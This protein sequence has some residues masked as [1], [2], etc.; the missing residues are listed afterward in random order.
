MIE[1]LYLHI[2]FCHAKCAYCDFCS[3]AERAEL[4]H[5]D[6]Y[7]EKLRALIEQL[8]GL[9]LFE[10][11]RSAYIGGGTPS[12]LM[13]DSLHLLVS[14]INTLSQSSLSELSVE[15]NPESLDDERLAALVA[16]GATRISMGLQSTHKLELA[17]LGRIHSA[18]QGLM[19]AQA[20]LQTPLTLSLDVM[21]G[22]PYQTPKSWSD[23]LDNLIALKPHH[24]S[25]YPLIIEEGTGFAAAVNR[26]D[27][28]E[29][30]EDLQAQYME[31]AQSVL[32]DAGYA[33]YEVASYALDG[34]LCLHNLMYWSG[35]EYLGLGSSAASM[36]SP[37]SYKRLQTVFVQLP[38]LQTDTARVRLRMESMA[39]ELIEVHDFSEIRFELEELNECEAVAEDFMLACRTAA[40]ISQQLLERGADVIDA[41]ALRRTIDMVIAQGLARWESNSLGQA[42][43]PTHTGWLLGNQLYGAFWDLHEHPKAFC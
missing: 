6:A 30:D 3:S 16:S 12:L 2:P 26:G 24:I 40:G 5:A 38:Q 43:I 19:R 28:D 35:G 41:D 21:C 37:T 13:P 25:C 7:A 32:T 36:L 31:Y 10:N 42:L 1:G 22:I 18:E 15:A 23:T 34:A 9:G 33:R 11:M 8:S 39:S 27:I 29:P 17:A 20:V 14:Q 4:A